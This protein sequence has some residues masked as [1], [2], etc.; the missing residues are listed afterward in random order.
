MMQPCDEEG[1]DSMYIFELS[2]T[3][4]LFYCVFLKILI[5]SKGFTLC[6][7]NMFYMHGDPSYKYICIL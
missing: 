5:H 3:L 2:L 6:R 1:I 4:Y 7:F